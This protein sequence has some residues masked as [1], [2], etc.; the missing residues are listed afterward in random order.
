MP[1]SPFPGVYFQGRNVSFREGK[2]TWQQIHKNIYHSWF[3]FRSGKW[4]G[5]PPSTQKIWA[6]TAATK[7]HPISHPHFEPWPCGHW[8][9]QTYTKLPPV[10]TN[11]IPGIEKVRKRHGL[12]VFGEM[13]TPQKIKAKGL[14]PPKSW[15]F[16]I[17]PDEEFRISIW[18]DVVFGGTLAVKFSREWMFH[19]EF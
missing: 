16:W 11:L 6:E 9:S 4:G 3:Y 12:T 5:K 10:A 18:G 14:E 15:R 8:Q 13:A 19:P 7:N 1:E 2:S 17:V